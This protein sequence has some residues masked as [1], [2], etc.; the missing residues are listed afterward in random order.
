[1][2]T[3]GAGTDGDSCTT[4]WKRRVRLHDDYTAGRLR[5]DSCTTAQQAG[6]KVRGYTMSTLLAGIDSRD[7]CTTAL[8]V[9]IDAELM[10]YFAAGQ[11][12]GAQLHYDGIA[13][14][15]KQGERCWSGERGAA[16]R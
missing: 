13:S 16:T 12:R 1:M 5:K 14:R 11:K 2:T 10:Q 9:G 7:S 3:P 15:D 4:G 8:L 6:R